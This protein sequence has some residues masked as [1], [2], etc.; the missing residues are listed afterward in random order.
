MVFPII[1][2]SDLK[3]YVFKTHFKLLVKALLATLQIGNN[4]NA[5]Q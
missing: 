3:M 5:L 4:Q 2:A 1:C